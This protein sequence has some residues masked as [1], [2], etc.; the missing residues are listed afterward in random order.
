MSRDPISEHRWLF[1][2]VR[3]VT[4]VISDA[5]THHKVGQRNLP[6]SPRSPPPPVAV[7]K[8]APMIN[9]VFTPFYAPFTVP[10]TPACWPIRD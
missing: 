10:S 2:A 6:L 8:V 5:Q 1:Y 7:A 9:Q 3:P 4:G